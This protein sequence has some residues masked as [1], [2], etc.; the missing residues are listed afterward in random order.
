[1]AVEMSA[2]MA[3]AMSSRA[4]AVPSPGERLRPGISGRSQAGRPTW[5][6]TSGGTKARGSATRGVSP[7]LPAVGQRP[8]GPLTPDR[9]LDTNSLCHTG[10]RASSGHAEHTRPMPRQPRGAGG[11]PLPA[12]QG[13]PLQ[14]SAVN[15]ES[16]LA[17]TGHSST[18]PV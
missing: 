15:A 6:A 3:A 5:I 4:S 13:L 8:A 16:G 9:P 11:R 7:A 17:A 14:G 10:L 18:L 2:I 1:M 12:L